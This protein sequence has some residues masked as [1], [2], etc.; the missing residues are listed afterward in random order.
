MDKKTKR[1]IFILAG[2]TVLLVVF[3]AI[4]SRPD[5][6]LHSVYKAIGTPFQYIQKGF[7]SFGRSIKNAISVIGDYSEIKDEVESL[8]EE[9]DTL[10]HLANENE[11]LKEE[12]NELRDLLGLKGYFEDYEMIAANIIAED[13]TDWF[14]EFTIDRGSADGIYNGC[15]I[16]TSKGL[17]GIVY[18]TGLVS[19]KARCIVDD[20]NILV[21]R[22]LRNNALVRVRGMSN[23]N[24]THMLKLDRIADQT[25]LYAGD[26]IVTAESGSVYPKGIVIGTV[27]ELAEDTQT[28]KRIAYIEPAVDFTS[29]T[30]VYVLLP[31]NKT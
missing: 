24:Y 20:Q 12:N 15:V 2:I 21:A 25:S 14:N 11:K 17:V 9:N 10:K 6:A 23:E 28:K 7:T 16:I 3:L 18:N 29:V 19:S 8:R 1:F 4:S 30:H 22:I 27:V 26:V 5:S 13:V 31:G